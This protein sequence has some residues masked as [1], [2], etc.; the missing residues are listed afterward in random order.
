MLLE[1]RQSLSKHDRDK[2]CVTKVSGEQPVGTNF[3]KKRR[4]STAHGH[5]DQVPKWMSKHVAAGTRDLAHS[6][7]HKGLLDTHP[8]FATLPARC[9]DLLDLHG[10]HFPDSRKNIMNLS[11]SK[12]C[13]WSGCRALDGCQQSVFFQS[14][15]VAR[16]RLAK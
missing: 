3:G 1:R 4:C 2:A 16:T 14:T 13:P 15:K 6:H 7:W 12:V 9:Q 10:V 11:Q 8:T 5:G